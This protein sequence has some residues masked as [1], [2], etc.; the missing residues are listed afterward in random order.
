MNWHNIIDKSDGKLFKNWGSR[1]LYSDF[2]PEFKY[3]YGTLYIVRDKKKSFYRNSPAPT[4]NNL[5]SP[6]PSL[7]TPFW[8]EA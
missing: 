3:T 4:L 6:I 1:S 5:I 2:E 7:N 8:E